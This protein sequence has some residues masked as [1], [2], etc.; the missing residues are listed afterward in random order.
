[1]P[2]WIRD[3]R[4]SLS[5]SRFATIPAAVEE[6]R[7]IY[8]NIK[9]CISFLLSSNLGEVMTV[10]IAMLTGIGTP[11]LPTQILW[12]NLV[13]DT[14]PALALGMEP[15]EPDIMEQPPMPANEG[16]FTKNT[17]L[18]ILSMGV[19]IAALA[20]TA[21]CLGLF[22]LPVTGPEIAHT[23]AFMVL[24]FSQLF[25]AFNMKSRHSLFRVGV[26]NN[27]YLLLA[28]VAGIALQCIIYFVPF[29]AGVFELATLNATH[30]LW[31]AILAVAPIPIMEIG[32][33]VVKQFRKN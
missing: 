1:M 25:H 29:L 8:Q 17:I 24:A 11:L 9:K 5:R 7:G 13:T 30:L 2:F 16:F 21:Y 32:K 18:H 10:F 23:M 28:L 15:G 4:R 26:T 22:W 6:G 33:F 27:K 12:V 14:L 31:V 19:M 20:L 3:R